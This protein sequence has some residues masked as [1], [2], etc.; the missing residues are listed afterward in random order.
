MSRP[1]HH[2]F[3]NASAGI[4]TALKEQR[5][6]KFHFL[7]ALLAI[8]LGIYFHISYVAWLFLTLTIGLV[9]ALELTNTAIEEIVNS[10]TEEVHPA[11]KKAKDV[12]AGAV[13]TASIMAFIIGLLIFLPHFLGLL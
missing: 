7:A 9:I 10:F 6:L 13:L 11:A 3:K 12:A 8:N 5:N 4:W 2:S 1:F